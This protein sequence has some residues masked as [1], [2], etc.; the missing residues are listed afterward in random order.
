LCDQAVG[1]AE[2]I[3]AHIEARQIVHSGNPHSVVTVSV[4]CC[5]A[6]P[7]TNLTPVTLVHHADQALYQAKQIGRNRVE[8]HT[9]VLREAIEV[10]NV[11]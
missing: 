8:W 3:R 11:T 10:Q 4:G 9:T 2:T 5:A 1:I 7:R 6:S